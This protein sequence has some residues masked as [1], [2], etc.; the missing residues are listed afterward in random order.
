VPRRGRGCTVLSVSSVRR[1][2]R[3]S[4]RATGETRRNEARS[5]EPATAR[6]ALAGLWRIRGES[7]G[8][9]GR[10]VSG[11]ST[12]R[13]AIIRVARASCR[14]RTHDRRRSSHGWKT[15]PFRRASPSE[16]SAEAGC[17]E[18]LAGGARARASGHMTTA[19]PHRRQ[20]EASRPVR[21]RR[22]SIHDVGL[23]RRG[24]RDPI[25]ARA[26]T[27]SSGLA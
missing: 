12:G 24:G 23:R 9:A 6:E 4:A 27:R 13:R 7:Q 22:R 25:A 21:R 10:F 18:A 3:G 11:T 26:F 8:C 15:T 16:M 17:H 20:R 2:G 1:R 14:P 19:A 5:G